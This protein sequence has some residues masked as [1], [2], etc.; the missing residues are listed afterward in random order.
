MLASG[1]KQLQRRQ[2]G[3]IVSQEGAKVTQK[4]AAGR[5]WILTLSYARLVNSV[6]ILCQGFAGA[7]VHAYIQ[8]G[9][10]SPEA[11][12]LGYWGS[13]GAE[14]GLLWPKGVPK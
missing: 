2:E 4:M 9:G 13:R 6:L 14:T 5:I 12:R 10:L 1:S 3:A 11:P 8:L 7:S